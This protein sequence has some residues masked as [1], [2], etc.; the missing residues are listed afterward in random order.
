MRSYVV[1]LLRPASDLLVCLLL[2]ML[3]G[4]DVGTSNTPTV[5]LKSTPA[6][7]QPVDLPKTSVETPELSPKPP[8]EIAAPIPASTVKLVIETYR[9]TDLIDLDTLK[10]GNT[11]TLPPL[12]LSVDI[13]QVPLRAVLKELA[14]KL[15][16]KV[17]IADGVPDP[18]ISLQLNGVDVAEGIKQ[19]LH[20]T[21]YV[22][23]YHKTPTS[24]K[25]TQST[26]ITSVGEI[27]EIHVL[28][29]NTT[30]ENSAT[31]KTLEPANQATDLAAWKN[32]ALSAQNPADRLMALK[33]FLDHA[34]P[35]EHN[36]L[37]IAALEDTAPEVRKLAINTMGD[38]TEPLIEPLSQTAL[39]DEDPQLRTAALD[40][41]VNRY[42]EE[43]TA[44][45]EQA[46]TDPDANV[47]QTAKNNLEMVQR[48]RNQMDTI[49]HRKPK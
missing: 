10:S 30:R 48:I 28:P 27:A 21:H 9:P 6:T 19:I 36:A 44:V 15:D 29:K 49:A 17:L 35:A 4:C 13:F 22:L 45:L 8:I 11:L 46:L 43:A 5:A 26:S 12:Q 16:A 37:L 32:Q 25:P 38:S 2:T 18:L 14:F 40:V 7:K 31:L 23:I 39:N 42:G 24:T 33:Q 41:L 1:P 47:Q 20:N 34:D 3:I